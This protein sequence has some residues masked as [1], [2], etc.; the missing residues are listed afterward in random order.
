MSILR[1][2]RDEAFS[3]VTSTHPQ[4]S[5]PLVCFLCGKPYSFP[6]IYWSGETGYIVF[7][8]SCCFVFTIKLEEDMKSI[9]DHHP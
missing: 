9:K 4:L 8:P 2:E 7:H 3:A 1:N 5:Q 6:C